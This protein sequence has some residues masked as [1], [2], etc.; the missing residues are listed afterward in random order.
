MKAVLIE[1]ENF[2]VQQ[3]RSLLK[4]VAPD[5][6]ISK[7]LD[8]IEST[9]E[10]FIDN[11]P[12]DLVFMDV[13]LADGSCFEIFSHVEIPCPVIFI[14]AYDQYALDAFRVNGLDYLL[15]PLK[16]ND[17]VRSLERFRKNHPQ[18]DQYL[19]YRRIAREIIQQSDQHQKRLL[20][21]YGQKITMIDITEVAYFFAEAKGTFICT[22]NNRQYPSDQNLEQLI[23]ILPPAE[24]YRVNRKIIVNVRAI[25]SMIAYSRSRIKLSLEPPFDQPI[26]VS[27]ER[28][29]GFKSWLT[30]TLD[31]NGE[32]RLMD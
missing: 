30:G 29:P 23:Q 25:S 7:V 10:W 1:D 20:V 12:P 14:T 5:I 6:E 27:T 19:D 17:L 24:F 4:E 2:A 8:S 31:E 26:I 21:K 13:H 32:T 15:K 16:K 22:F 9:I 11:T 3:V 18:Q 28:T